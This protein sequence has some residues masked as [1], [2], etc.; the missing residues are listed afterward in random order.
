MADFFNYDNAFFRL[1]TRIAHLLYLNLLWIL[2]SLPVVTMGAA[3]AALHSVTLKMVRNEE[4]YIFA[5]FWKAFRLNFQ[6]ATGIWLMIVLGGG[7]LAGD[8]FYF[9]RWANW[10]GV[11]C[12]GLFCICLVVL[13]L[14]CMVVFHLQA[15]FK[16][17]VKGTFSNAIRFTFRHLPS[18]IALLIMFGCMAYGFYVTVPIM[19]IELFI[20]VSFFSYVSSY[21]FRRIFDQYER[22]TYHSNQWG[23]GSNK[24]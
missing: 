3:T 23:K 22:E 11:F 20:G 19:I 1:I 9:A 5:N 21:L 8:V 18:N 4:G 15:R 12:A 17:N 2:F 7:V 24:G 16:N 6:Q 13:A 14:T 10:A